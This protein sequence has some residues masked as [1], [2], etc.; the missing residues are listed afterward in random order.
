ML[1]QKRVPGREG[2]VEVV[3]EELAARMA[4]LGVEVTLINRRRRGVPR[5]RSYAGARVR[6][7]PTV[8]DPRLNAVVYAFFAMLMAPSAPMT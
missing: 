4:K 1:G 5:I 8:E 3:V 7:A 6:W 2:G